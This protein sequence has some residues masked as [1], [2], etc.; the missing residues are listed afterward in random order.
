[1]QLPITPV[2]PISKIITA[3]D[4]VAR[5]F[6]NPDDPLRQA[7]EL[8]LTS[9][10]SMEMARSILD[11]LF[12][13]L[14][15]PQLFQLLEE[16]LGDPLIMDRFRPRR[17]TTGFTRAYGPERITHILPGNIPDITIMSLVFA[18][19]SKS[20]S[21]V[22]VSSKAPSLVPL[23]LQ[24]L[25][26]VDQG[27][28]E[29]IVLIPDRD[30][31]IS[32]IDAAF[33]WANLIILYG[34]DETIDFFHPHIPPQ[35]K[36]IIYGPKYSIGIVSR[37]STSRSVAEACAQDI[38]MYDQKG[39][40]SPHIYYIERGGESPLQYAEWV[41]EALEKISPSKGPIQP[42]AASRIQQLRGT[43]PLTGGAVFASKESIDW[44]VLYDPDTS[45]TPSPLCR[46]IFIKSVQDISDIPSLLEPVRSHLQAIGV[47]VAPSR[48]PLLL[49]ALGALGVSRLCPIGKMQEPPLTWHHD[50]RF[51]LLDLLHFVDYEGGGRCRALYA[52]GENAQGIP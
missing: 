30:H 22:K 5:I 13:Q 7:A 11:H 24:A 10:Y 34:S 33:H 15:Q 6:L 51:R 36:T 44:T 49:D 16:E 20:A 21:M 38:A 27:L 47:A 45:F 40:L 23:F 42:E 32:A 9:V 37:D 35:K 17:H 41:A 14:T 31:N 29:S 3:I 43:I 19:L 52:N 50:G 46:T 39:C 1:M 48:L 8:Q 4:H 2:G 18:L 12:D 28:S 26:K 25:Q